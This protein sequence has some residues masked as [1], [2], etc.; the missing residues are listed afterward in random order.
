MLEAKKVLGLVVGKEEVQ[1]GASHTKHPIEL[2]HVLLFDLQL[3][4]H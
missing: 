2:A 3:L 1:L 4:L